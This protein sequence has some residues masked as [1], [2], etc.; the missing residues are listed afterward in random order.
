M[1]GSQSASSANRNSSDAKRSTFTTYS[2]RAHHAGS[3]YD[4]DANDLRDALDS[5]LREAVQEMPSACDG[6][7]LSSRLRGVIV[8]HAGYRYSGRTAAYAYAA[9]Q[10][11]IVGAAQRRASSD[12]WDSKVVVVVLHP[13]HHVYLEGCAVS[14]A[15]QLQTPLG[16]LVVDDALRDEIL[17]L[18]SNGDTHHQQHKRKTPGFTIMSQWED[19]HEHSG[20]M[21]YPFLAHVL[22]SCPKGAVSV[23]PIMVGSVST[24]QEERFGQLLAPILARPN[25]VTVVSS[26]FCHWG[27]RF[28]YRPTPTKSALSTAQ[29]K[30]PPPIHEFIAQLDRDGMD[31]IERQQPGAFARYL[32]ET[33]NTICGRHPIAVWLNAST[34]APVPEQLEVKFVKYAQSGAVTGMHESSVSYAAAV[35]TAQVGG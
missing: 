35:A 27:S 18:N 16:D 22:A 9:L 8:P 34:A 14:G 6:I 4:D 7:P 21:Q 28:S 1:H 23:L 19:E 26:D 15:H 3:W 2:R 29:A 12:D 13:S 33:K 30:Q 32:R 11:Q 20:E 24:E 25:V 10:R 5:Y 17:H 31:L